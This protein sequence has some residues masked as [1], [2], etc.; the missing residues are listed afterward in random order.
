MRLQS[1]TLPNGFT[2][3]LQPRSEF[4]VNEIW[5][6]DCYGQDYRIKPGDT[7]LDLGAN[8]GLFALYAAHLGAAV[9]CYEPVMDIFNLLEENIKR[10]GLAEKVQAHRYAVCAADGEIDI[11]IPEVSDVIAPGMASINSRTL[12]GLDRDSGVGIKM[13]KVPTRRL[14][15]ILE[16]M[17]RVDLLK[18]DCEGAELDILRSAT[19]DQAS[20][21]RNLVMETH[22]GYSQKELCARIEELGF[23]VV[24]FRPIVSSHSAGY[25]FASRERPPEDRI[26]ALL[27]CKSNA[28]RG[29]RFEVDASESFRL[30]DISGRLEYE[31]RIDGIMCEASKGSRETYLPDPSRTVSQI[32]L[33][34]KDETGRSASI[35][36]SIR[37]LDTGYFGFDPERYLESNEVELKLYTGTP[38]KLGIRSR[39]FPKFSRFENI[40]ITASARLSMDATLR[41]DNQV[42]ALNGFHA[43][44]DLV[45]FPDDLDLHIELTSSIEQEL[46]LAWWPVALNSTELSNTQVRT[47]ADGIVMP[48]EGQEMQIPGMKTG[49]F[50]IPKERLPATWSPGTLAVMVSFTDFAP[51]QKDA[52]ELEI[53]GAKSALSGWCHIERIRNPG[54][55]FDIRGRIELPRKMGL[56]LSWWAEA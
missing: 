39:H 6:L 31:W 23:H 34:V 12:E 14:G 22:T 18:V 32:Q 24:S 3:V 4:I 9:Q 45:G 55:A 19:A 36:K 8:Q 46:I 54:A 13:E 35:S 49:D 56:K 51:S 48:A 28:F 37:L 41:V 29:E 25:L 10:N 17:G 52:G 11:A 43:Q 5:G 30:P 15:S 16:K 26:V 20:I 1:H 50:V 2:A 38:L 40:R 44:V 33:T 7:V 21:I 53:N 42:F 47:I 27:D